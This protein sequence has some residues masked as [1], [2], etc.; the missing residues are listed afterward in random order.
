MPTVTNNPAERRFQIDDGELIAKLTYHEGKGHI[1]LVHT[2]VPPELGGR[3]YAGALAKYALE[4]ARANRL[5]V[6]A[7]CPFVR[8]FLERHPEYADLT[9]PS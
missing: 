2:E 7:H 4:Y 6:I 1:T 3:G 9:E 8:A 5:R